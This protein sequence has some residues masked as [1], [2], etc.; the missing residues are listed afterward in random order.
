M[1]RGGTVV[2][3]WWHGEVARGGTVVAR[4]WHGAFCIV[5]KN[6]PC[7]FGSPHVPPNKKQISPNYYYDCLLL[8]ILSIFTHLILLALVGG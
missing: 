2:A 4:W 1:Y 8:L 5:Q 3:R 6:V 7:T